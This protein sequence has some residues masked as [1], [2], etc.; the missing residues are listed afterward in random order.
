MS[1][2]LRKPWRWQLAEGASISSDV[3]DE[4]RAVWVMEGDYLEL[5]KE[6]DRLN[7]E[8]KMKDRA[9]KAADTEAKAY[10]DELQD[11]K[12]RVK[13][14]QSAA[15]VIASVLGDL[16]DSGQITCA[17]S[18]GVVR[19]SLKRWEEAKEGKPSV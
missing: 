19:S 17:I 7:E 3:K 13:R 10:F 12:P 2:D 9:Y 5:L 15:T 1:K 16:H 11:L 18:K 6:V 8:I 14:V 4:N